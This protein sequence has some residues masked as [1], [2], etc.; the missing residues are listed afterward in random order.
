ML[1]C[2]VVQAVHKECRS[3]STMIIGTNDVT[4]SKNRT[5]A[6]IAVVHQSIIFG[7]FNA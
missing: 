7:H 2:G 6:F 1:Y 3:L 4:P 5:P